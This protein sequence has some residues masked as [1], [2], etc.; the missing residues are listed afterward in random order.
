MTFDECLAKTL[1]LE[2]GYSDNP[3]DHGAATMWG[4]T[5]KTYDAWRQSNG[6]SIRKVNFLEHEEMRKI[7]KEHYWLAAKCEAFTDLADLHFDAA[8]QHG[9]RR[10]VM[11]LQEALG[12]APDG[13]LGNVTMGAWRLSDAA[14]VRARY[15]IARY[16]FYGRIAAKD[17]TQRIFLTGWMNR[18]EC[19]S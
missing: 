2:G 19:F 17:R 18:M 12:V 5:Q 1:T 6:Q 16:R 8:V 9:A 13:V 11:L 7:Y 3:F 4:I 15:I 10:A 14:M